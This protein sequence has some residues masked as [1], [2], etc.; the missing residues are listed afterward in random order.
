M[1]KESCNKTDPALT[2]EIMPTP[3]EIKIRLSRRTKEEAQEE[4][5]RR[6]PEHEARRNIHKR[7]MDGESSDDHELEE[8]TRRRSNAT[9][10]PDQYI[11]V[12]AAPSLAMVKIGYAAQILNRVELIA[13]Y[14]PVPLEV[15]LSIHSERLVVK[16]LEQSIHEECQPYYS[17]GEWFRATPEVIA[18]I[19]RL[20]THEK[21]TVYSSFSAVIERWEAT[22]H[23]P[24]SS[25]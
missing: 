7:L 19:R 17:H 23:S 12:L 22:D 2:S 25:I 8:F 9:Q 16:K 13:R 3:P 20:A 18:V 24:L 1:A 11:Y 4:R 21:A 14:S 6:K 15:I 5:T 10:N